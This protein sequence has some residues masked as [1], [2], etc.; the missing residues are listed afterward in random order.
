MKN[1]NG[2]DLKARPTDDVEIGNTTYTPAQAG[3]LRGNVDF[4][5][6]APYFGIG[7]GSAAKG[8]KRVRFA[9]DLGVLQQGS[10]DVSI[11]SSSRLVSSDDLRQEEADLEDDIDNYKLWPVI[12]LGISFRL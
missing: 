8:P 12:A 5:D 1:R 7:Y 6:T 9:F 3:T 4:N 11:S 10:G 2:I